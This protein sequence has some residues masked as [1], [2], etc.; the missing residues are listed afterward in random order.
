MR[1]P[2]PSCGAP[3]LRAAL[4]LLLLVLLPSSSPARS[5]SRSERNHPS[6]WQLLAR[7][8]EIARRRFGSR[9]RLEARGTGDEARI[10]F[11]GLGGVQELT[12]EPLPLPPGPWALSSFRLLG[13]GRPLTHVGQLEVSLEQLPDPGRLRPLHEA[14]ELYQELPDGSWIPLFALERTPRHLVTLRIPPGTG[15]FVIGYRLD[16]PPALHRLQRDLHSR[17]PVTIL[18][19]GY[20]GGLNYYT[21]PRGILTWAKGFS[22]RVHFFQYP[23]GRPL[24]E[25]AEAL[26]EALEDLARE[27][28][29]ERGTR[30]VVLAYSMGG[31]VARRVLEGGEVPVR[32]QDL[33]L[34]AS[35]SQGV[36][37]GSL[38]EMLPFLRAR[39][40]RHVRHFPGTAD[41][42]SGSDFLRRLNRNPRP[43]PPI[44]YLA[45]AARVLPG[46]DQVVPV[47]STYVPRRRHPREYRHVTRGQ[48][49]NFDLYSHSGARYEF[50]RN[51]FSRVAEEWLGLEQ[52]DRRYQL[53]CRL[54]RLRFY[55]EKLRSRTGSRVGA[56]RTGALDRE[57]GDA[58]N[59]GPR[60]T[61]RPE[62]RAGALGQGRRAGPGR[63][64]ERSGMPRRSGQSQPSR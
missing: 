46:T 43:P 34:L 61:G 57:I 47:R 3:F 23:S 29:E 8:R 63:P 40:R 36:P 49:F 26:R 11:Q 39:V 38:A 7:K 50:T 9:P 62:M 24:E 54:A 20:D 6:S 53:E 13:D 17:G 42:F 1:L 59:Q 41:L 12:W 21:D 22:R 44:R 10:F 52:P 35:P 2:A 33:I 30:H 14:V 31:L 51:G 32:V 48:Y 58:P 5:R 27:Y 16:Q 28:P 25:A 18:V 60:A 45:L 15:R 19:H 4:V 56:R 55:Q 37:Y 64:T